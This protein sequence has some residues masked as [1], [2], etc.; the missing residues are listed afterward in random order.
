[1]GADGSFANGRWQIISE[2]K[3]GS[4]LADIANTK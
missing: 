2:L 3:T 4:K 1:M